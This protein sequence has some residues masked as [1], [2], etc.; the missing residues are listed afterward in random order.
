MPVTVIIAQAGPVQWGENA[1]SHTVHD[2]A[3][4]N[5]DWWVGV[6][7]AAAIFAPNPCVAAL[8]MDGEFRSTFCKADTLVSLVDDYEEEIMGRVTMEE[9][10]RR[11]MQFDDG[12][13]FNLVVH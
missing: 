9:A 8:T 10:L 6:Q 12:V 1:Y 4:P 3:H 2:V 5:L 11:L 13:H 7:D